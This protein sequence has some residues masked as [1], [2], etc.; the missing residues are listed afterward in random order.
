MKDV[1]DG[2]FKDMTLE[3]AFGIAFSLKSIPGTSN[4]VKAPSA[5]P[6]SFPPTTLPTTV[7][8]THKF[9][10]WHC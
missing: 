8:P 1:V 5:P 7:S 2:G 3:D 9:L 10:C 6:A 4:L